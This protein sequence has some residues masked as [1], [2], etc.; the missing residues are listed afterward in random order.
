MRNKMKDVCAPCKKEVDELKKRVNNLADS[1]NSCVE[2]QLKETDNEIRM[3]GKLVDARD[4]MCKH[5]IMIYILI[6]GL[7]LPNM[8]KFIMSFIR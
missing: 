6:F 7:C 2:F 8:I 1:L 4:F 3:I 5:I